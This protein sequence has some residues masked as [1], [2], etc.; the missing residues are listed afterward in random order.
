MVKPASRIE[1]IPPYLFARIDKKKEEARQKGIN[2]ID[3]GI[4]DPDI[5]TPVNIIQKMQEATEDSRNHRYPS[6]EGMLSFRKTVADWYLKRFGVGLNP[7]S[8]VVTLIGSK[9]GIAHMPLAYVE[10]GDVVLVP[11]P[12]YPV[13]R[14]STLLCGG[15]PYI[16]PLREENGYLPRLEDIPEEVLRKAKI[17]FINYPNNPTGACADDLF[18]KKALD[19]AK[20]YDILLCHDAAYSEIAYDGY[21]PKS[22]LQFDT[23][24]KYS[25]EFHS[26]SKTYCMTGWRI[27]FAVGNADAIYNLGKLKTNIDSGVFQAIQYAGI[28]AITGDQSS[29]EDL[30]KRFQQRRDLV[31]DGLLS[32]GIKVARPRATFYI[33]AKVPKGYTS[34]SFCEKLIEKTGVVVTPGNGFGDEGEGYFRIS[35]TNNEKNIREAIRRLKTLKL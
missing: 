4:G 19:V 27:G 10:S 7:A 35:T 28:E 31:V 32:M 12:G 9:E 20:E 21:M 30:K 16:M 22:V 33:W 26:L 13:Y 5:P 15:T 1:K 14:I 3:L 25:V 17:L 11:S 29:L 6:Y 23:E 2:I 8:E 24:K 34:E 18:Y